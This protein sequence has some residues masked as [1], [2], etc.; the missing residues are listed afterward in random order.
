MAIYPAPDAPTPQLDGAY[1]LVTGASRGIGQAM[2][3]ALAGAGAHVLALARTVGGLEELDDKIRARKGKC[4]LIPGDVTD[5]E[6][7]ERL[8]AV[9]LERFG[10]L[11]IL[12]A[13]AGD[14]GELAPLPDV[15]PKIWSRTFDVNVHAN[16]RLLKA[17]DP[18]L[19]ASA[20]GRAIFLTSRVGGQE[21]RAF[22]G[23]YAASKAA[24]EMLA[25][26]Y[27]EE[28]ASTEVRVALIDPGAMR[29]KMRAQ[30][31][32]GEDAATLPNPSELA[33][34]VLY[35]ASEDYDGR[36]ERLSFR[37]WKAAHA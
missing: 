21:A 27:A 14:L 16:W 18:A 15:D 36:A 35:A 26:T 10:R 28:T 13:N 7:I 33:P 4:S 6:A 34:L 1:A 30:A 9:I 37:E 2:A 29:T 12:L 5:P 24:L 32:P 3:I 25:K 17:L 20:A 22:W 23:A 8:G 11:D 19:R 31:M